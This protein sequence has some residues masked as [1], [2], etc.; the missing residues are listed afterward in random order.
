MFCLFILVLL[1]L[2]R[3]DL[4]ALQVAH[5]KDRKQGTGQNRGSMQMGRKEMAFSEENVAGGFLQKS[6]GHE[7]GPL[8][9]SR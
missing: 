2:W 9:D 7:G 3:K 6:D 4:S 8:V 1:Y 5:S